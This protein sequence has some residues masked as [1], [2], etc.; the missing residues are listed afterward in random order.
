[1]RA[2]PEWR[3]PIR[4]TAA[5]RRI[6]RGSAAP[7]ASFR[8][9]AT[10]RQTPATAPPRK[11]AARTGTRWPEREGEREDDGR[12][13]AHRTGSGWTRLVRRRPRREARSEE[14]RGGKVGRLM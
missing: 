7:D 8:A 11:P 14:G 13:C 12:Y 3:M 2:A 4:R 5:P 10:A 1:M 9:P 6:F